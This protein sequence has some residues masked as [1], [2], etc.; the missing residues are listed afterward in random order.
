LQEAISAYREICDASQPHVRIA[1]GEGS[2]TV[3]QAEDFIVNG[4]AAVIQ[5]SNYRVNLRSI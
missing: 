3:R 4:G 1:G 5:A 2:D